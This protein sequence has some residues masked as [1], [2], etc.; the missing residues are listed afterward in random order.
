MRLKKI[1][2]VTDRNWTDYRENKL[3]FKNDK[4]SISVSISPL[5]IGIIKQERP[6]PTR[7]KPLEA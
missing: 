5:T 4:Y 2:I 3:S 1:F 6:K 7:G